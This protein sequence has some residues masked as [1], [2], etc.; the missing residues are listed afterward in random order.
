MQN[1]Y[2]HFFQKTYRH[3]ISL[4]FYNLF[5]VKI[6][7]IHLPLVHQ[8]KWKAHPYQA[9]KV[10][11]TELK[12]LMSSVALEDRKKMFHLYFIFIFFLCSLKYVF[13]YFLL[14]YYF[15]QDAY[16]MVLVF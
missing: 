9:K 5:L 3:L 4:F 1:D 13:Q 7:L 6:N 10:Y 16:L 2:L 11:L 14:K 15:K 12:V 8:S